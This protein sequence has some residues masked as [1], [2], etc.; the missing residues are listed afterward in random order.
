MSLMLLIESQGATKGR[1]FVEA[2]QGHF[3]LLLKKTLAC[4]IWPDIGRFKQPG[5]SHG[6]VV[7]R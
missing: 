4:K 3:I 2:R 5:S 7:P 6:L 1:A